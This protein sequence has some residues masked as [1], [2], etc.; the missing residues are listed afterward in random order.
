VAKTIIY[1]AD[2]TWDGP[3]QANS[4]DAAATDSNVFKLFLNLAGA[5]T[6]ANMLLAKEQ[7]R[8]LADPAGSVVQI[9]EY[10]HGVGDSSNLL[11]RFLGGTF[12]AG[13]ITRIVRGYTFVSRNYRAADRIV[14]VGFSRGAYTARALAGLI[15]AQ[16]L[17]DATQLD[18]NDKGTAYRLG[19]AVW[20]QHRRQ[21][22][23]RGN[24]DWLN[25]LQ[26]VVNDLPG[27]LQH[28]P[29]ANQLITAPIEAVAVWDTVGAYGIP[30]Y[31]LDRER[32]D[33]Y[34]FADRVLSPKVR[35]GIHAVAVDEQRADFTPT[36][37]DADPRIVQTLFP[38][39]HSDVG[40]GYPQAGNESGLSDAS[41]VWMTDQLARIGV[42][43]CAPVK[44]R[45]NPDAKGIAHEPWRHDQW[46]F[47]LKKSRTFPPGLGCSQSLGDR[48]IAGPVLA[49]PGTVAAKYD[50]PNLHHYPFVG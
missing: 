44:Y 10:M 8:T 1:L 50:P 5:D 39:A 12:G 28:P 19:S 34:Q 31:T 30:Q 48:L 49:E 40:G 21:V 6:A 22:G 14:I 18:L 16:G 4:S 41:L 13:L 36:L 37:W 2:G 42:M 24:Q 32:V 46:Q 33:A 27:F 26:S 7:E 3:G 20:Y 9:A 45:P 11:N 38:G 17:L 43:F 23:A 29:P 15:T 35:F 47:L 25:R